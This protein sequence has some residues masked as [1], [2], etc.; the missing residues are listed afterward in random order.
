ML[1]VN[2]ERFESKIDFLDGVRKNIKQVI[3]G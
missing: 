1:E 3:N 2:S